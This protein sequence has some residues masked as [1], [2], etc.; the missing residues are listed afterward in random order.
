MKKLL[1]ILLA[2]LLVMSM[3]V[4]A[5]AAGEGEGEGSGTPTEASG[6]AEGEDPHTNPGN[7][8]ESV[9]VKKVYTVNGEKG[10]LVP[11]ETLTFAVEAAEGNPDDKMIT[12]ADLNTAESLDIVI[13]FP[14][15]TKMGIYEYTVT[16]NAGELENVTY[17]NS[18]IRVVVTVINST[19][20]GDN[21][22]NTLVAYVGVFK[23]VAGSTTEGST[24]YKIGGDP[25]ADP[26]TH[27]EDFEMAAFTNDYQVGNLTVKK[28]VHGNLANND[29]AFTINVTFEG[30]VAGDCAITYGDGQEVTAENPEA[31][32]QL[33]HNESVVFENIPIGVTYTVEED[34]AHTRGAINSEEGY[35]V[36]YIGS[37]LEVAEPEEADANDQPTGADTAAGEISEAAEEDDVTVQNYKNTEIQ[38]GIFLDSLP[39]ILIGV[40]VVAVVVVMII[41]KKRNSEEE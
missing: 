22:E 14:E 13:S 18:S 15:Y 31:T 12:V 25:Q 17:D 11:T 38:T 1:T 21:T 9:T 36:N 23:E 19:A 41:R 7:P 24:E 33:K 30:L 39:Y 35:Q 2:A 27:E 34:A 20:G 5:F 26:G 32:I 3:T 6:E 10:N 40:V 4:S 8:H 28:T 37:D 29:K 16:E